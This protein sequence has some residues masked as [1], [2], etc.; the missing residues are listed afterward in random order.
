MRSKVSNYE[1]KT[2]YIS[3]KKNDIYF[4]G[5]SFDSGIVYQPHIYMLARY[6]AE[7]C[8]LEYII[9]IGAGN[10]EKIKKYLDGY[11]IIA[12]DCQ[13]NL[14]ELAQNLPGQEIIDFDLEKGLPKIPKEIVEKS[15]VISS[16]VIE[17]IVNLKRYLADLSKMSKIAP[18]VLISTPDRDRARGIDDMGPPVNKSHVREWT[19]SELHSLLHLSGFNNLRTGYTINTNIHKDKSTIISIS[20]AHN[21]TTEAAVGI[22]K[23]KVQAIVTTHNVED[24]IEHVATHILNQGVDIYFIDNWSSDNTFKIISSLKKKYGPRIAIEKFPESK[25]TKYEWTRLLD[26]IDEVAKNSSY[27]WIIHYDSDEIRYSPNPKV[28]LQD[29]ISFVDSLGYNLIDHT[30]LDFRPIDNKYTGKISPEEAIEFYEYGKRPGHFVQFKAWKN[31]KNEVHLSN[32]GGHNI[33][34]AERQVYPLKFLIKHY[35]LR[36]QRQAEKKIFKDRIPRISDVDKAK[37]WHD[38]YNKFQKE[39][40]FVWDPLTLNKY[41]RIM[42]YQEN[43]VELISGI[44]IL[45]EKDTKD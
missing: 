6:L 2:G 5:T 11:K 1:I 41:H 45:D 21:M 20:G 10:G 38:Q 12:V 15:V 30:V 24:I 13:V 44:G 3:R 29:A 31:Q 39:S 4:D 19:A 37:G 34:I 43:L 27:D 28:S 23:K 42:S 32:S 26:R 40:V 33:E 25:T 22:K 35:P 17:H 7:T 36:S 8:G 18:F 16:D 14:T 9:D